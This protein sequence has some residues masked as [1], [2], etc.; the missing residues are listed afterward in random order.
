MNNTSTDK[1]GIVTTESMLPPNTVIVD[2]ADFPMVKFTMHLRFKLFSFG[3]K[4]IRLR[5]W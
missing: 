5:L 1:N 2:Y 3:M 4:M